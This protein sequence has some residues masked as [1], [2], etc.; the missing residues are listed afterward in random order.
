MRFS[1]L[2]TI[3]DLLQSL[4]RLHARGGQTT[5]GYRDPGLFPLH[6]W[7]Q[8][9]NRTPIEWEYRRDGK[10]IDPPIKENVV[11][12][13]GSGN[14]NRVLELG[15]NVKTP[16]MD[17]PSSLHRYTGRRL[18]F[19]FPVETKVSKVSGWHWVGRRLHRKSAVPIGQG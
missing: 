12:E 11:N 7:L 14:R 15:P 3:R 13:T 17:I 5:L 1:R 19:S 18:P 10:E 9:A 8:R 16:Y 2:Q 4:F 6:R